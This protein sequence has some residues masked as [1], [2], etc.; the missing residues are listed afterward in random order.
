MALHAVSEN[1]VEEHGR[2]LALQDGRSDE[3]FRQRCSPQGLQIRDDRVGGADQGGLVG[4]S[5]DLGGI[6]GLVPFQVHAVLGPG[7]GLDGKARVVAA[8]LNAGSFR[9][10]DPAIDA[11]HLERD[12]RAAD[13]G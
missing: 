10:G 3:G 4:Q 13:V 12:A 1:L 11:G 5:R 9:V 6:E 8:G 2:R 7:A